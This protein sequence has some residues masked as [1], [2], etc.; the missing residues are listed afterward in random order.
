MNPAL[1]NKML[2]GLELGH[3]VDSV[4]CERFCFYE[5]KGMFASD[6]VSFF[7]PT[8]PRSYSVLPALSLSGVLHVKVVENISKMKN[9][10]RSI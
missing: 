4:H 3:F 1:I 6:R 8:L 2:T 10:T 9:L 7:W 5:E